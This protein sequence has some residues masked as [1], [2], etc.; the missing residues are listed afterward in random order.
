[1]TLN[2]E[3][4]ARTLFK[5]PGAWEIVNIKEVFVGSE[6]RGA[7]KRA[8]FAGKSTEEDENKVGDETKSGVDEIEREGVEFNEE[9]GFKEE[10]DEEKTVAPARA[11]KLIAL[12]A[13]R[14]TKGNMIDFASK[15]Q[16]LER[17]INKKKAEKNGTFLQSLCIRYF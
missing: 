11:A 14:L 15:K 2:L 16:L 17:K 12:E 9:T 4:V 13:L 8:T 1:M 7:V 5:L 6:A 10:G 3:K